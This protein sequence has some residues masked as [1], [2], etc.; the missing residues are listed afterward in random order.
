MKNSAYACADTLSSFAKTD[1]L[2]SDAL[3]HGVGELLTVG[4]GG[5]GAFEDWVAARGPADLLA[6]KDFDDHVGVD[7]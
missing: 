5:G 3:Q 6:G 4:A 2:N 1:P 7:T